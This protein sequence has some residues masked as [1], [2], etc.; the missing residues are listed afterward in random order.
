VNLKGHKKYFYYAFVISYLL[1]IVATFFLQYNRQIDQSLLAILKRVDNSLFDNFFKS[2]ESLATESPIVI[3]AIDEKSLTQLGRW[4]SWPRQYY[5][6]VVNKLNQYG[7]KVV[8]F[9]VVFDAQDKVQSVKILEQLESY[10]QNTGKDKKILDYVQKSKMDLSTDWML[11]QAIEVFQR[12]K[13]NAV[14]LGY[15]VAQQ[16]RKK[17]STELPSELK[18][19]IR[20][21]LPYRPRGE[22]PEEIS[23][24]ASEY[25]INYPQLLKQTP[26]Y[27]YFSMAA[28][29]DGVVRHYALIRGHYGY[30]FPSLA[31]KMYE[32]YIES[33]AIVDWIEKSMGVISFAGK[34]KMLPIAND[35]LMRIHYF[36]AQNSFKTVALSDVINSEEKIEVNYRGIKKL[37]SKAELFNAKIAIIGAT[38][39]GIYDVRNT[40]VQSNLP[41]VEIHANVLNQL[42]QNHI[43][44]ELNDVLLVK[45]LL[46]MGGLLFVLTLLLINK[47][48][49]W[50]VS[51]MLLY[52]IA[53]SFLY[54]WIF[55]QKIVMYLFPSLFVFTFYFVALNIYRYFL[56]EQE[57][58]YIRKTFQS[59]VSPEVAKAMLESPEK[60]KLGGEFK[61]LTVLFSDV[62]SFTTMAEN[63]SPDILTRTLNEYLSFMTEQ[64]FATQGTLDKYIGDAVMAFW[65]APLDDH[66]HA[67]HAVTCALQMIQKQQIFKTR[68][69]I[70]TGRVSVGNMGS[71]NQFAYTV[72]GDAV[73]L[74]SR[75]ENLNK[76][77]QT[78]ILIADETY[79][80]IKN[81]FV[82]RKIDV[83][84]V[85][86]K[87]QVIT[88]YEVLDFISNSE[89]YSTIS[90]FEQAVEIYLKGEFEQAINL[91]KHEQLQADKVAKVL[92][93]RCELLLLTPADWRGV[94]IYD[95]K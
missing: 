41:G 34:K 77:Y 55:E 12:T 89:K 26:H 95:F 20:S 49:I 14:V 83:V 6:E 46:V 37:E 28:D 80:L 27:G 17:T 40:P 50:S 63:M 88:L 64:V 68:I 8:G 71:T 23:Y 2:K 81:D 42:L 16:M 21:T 47:S 24:A 74:A 36:G 15:F 60:I 86:G 56:S 78:Q 3:V 29:F 22:L 51:F 10:V 53:N 39:T 67:K 1:L 72:I 87:S 44:D 90:I 59:Y 54:A 45:Y 58:S 30:L 11:E 70:N 52:Y 69:G 38:A 48:F 5:A 4:Q 92:L 43:Y 79:Q 84:S 25:G 57:N 65:G 91:F 7:V 35:G 66:E 93:A 19:V 61:V 76:Y 82:C 94:W 31:L 75:L 32:T 18:K 33:P 9:D 85:A 13:G 62:E 73:N